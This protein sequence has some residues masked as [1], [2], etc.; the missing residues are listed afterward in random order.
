MTGSGM[1]QARDL[2]AEETVE[3]VRN[4]EGGTGFRGWFP[5]DRST[6]RKARVGVDAR[7]HVG[8][9]VGAVPGAIRLDRSGIPREEVGQPTGATGEYSEG[10]P[11]P[12]GPL[13]TTFFR[14]RGIGGARRKTSKTRRVTGKVREGAEKPTIRYGWV[15]GEGICIG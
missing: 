7:W 9:G 14:E 13:D 1:Q 6:G 11:R 12:E 10:E 5:R 2:R 4:H 8:G 15:P 3:V